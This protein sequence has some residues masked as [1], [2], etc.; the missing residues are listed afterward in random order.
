MTEQETQQ[1]HRK[2]LLLAD[3]FFEAYI[4]NAEDTLERLDE[5]RDARRKIE[6][7]PDGTRF[8]HLEAHRVTQLG[9]DPYH[10]SRF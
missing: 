3:A 7:G 6:K 4:S 1:L 9:L 2:S 10:P 8:G 5:Y